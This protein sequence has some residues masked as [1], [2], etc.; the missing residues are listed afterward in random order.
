MDS[1]VDIEP[2]DY[3]RHA[4]LF[5]FALELANQWHDEFFV[6]LLVVRLLFHNEDDVSGFFRD[7]HAERIP[8]C[9]V[10]RSH[11]TLH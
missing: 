8:D 5:Q 9:D 2:A 10:V 6:N 7:F 11:L 1:G 3:S 4:L